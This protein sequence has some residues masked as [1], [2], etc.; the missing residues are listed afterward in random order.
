MPTFLAG[1]FRKFY[2]HSYCRIYYSKR[3]V[4][5]VMPLF[6]KSLP[7]SCHWPQRQAPGSYG[8]HKEGSRTK[9]LLGG[10]RIPWGK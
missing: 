8:R 1:S 4:K 7:Q 9:M 3:F 6:L 2:R 10:S 5:G